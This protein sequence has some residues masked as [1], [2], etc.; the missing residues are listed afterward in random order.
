MF[1]ALPAPAWGGPAAVLDPRGDVAARAAELTWLLTWGALVIFVI[2]LGLLAVALWGPARLR[3][4]LGRRTLVMAGGVVFPVTVLT[5][6][7]AYTLGPGWRGGGAEARVHIE[8][9]G[10]MWWWR[11]RYTDAAGRLLFETANDIRIPVGQPVR[12]TLRS[13]DV[14]HS[15]WVPQLAGKLDMVPGRATTLHLRAEAA[16]TYAGVCAEFCGAQ[17]ARM[18]FSVA[19][20]PPDDYAAWALGQA[21]PA[22]APS[23]AR[24]RA[25]QA[26]FERHCMACHAIRGARSGERSGERSAAAAGVL[27][28]PDLTH[29]AGRPTLGAGLLPNNIGTLAGWIA[30][31]QQLKPGNRMPSFDRFDSD[32]LLAL[33]AYLDSLE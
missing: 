26:L 21:A 18:R 20:L 19:A 32:A 17:H 24:L 7:L 15:F 28:G 14:I 11:V 3:R 2:T 1:A 22:R 8:V 5:A 31:S 6:L 33:A 13:A 12:F 30:A 4:G 23:T 27:D 9:T 16:G 25:G 29:V 10:E